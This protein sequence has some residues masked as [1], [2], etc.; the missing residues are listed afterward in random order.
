V[1]LTVEK[2]GLRAGTAR[3]RNL[4]GSIDG[5]WDG[6]RLALATDIGGAGGAAISVTADVPLAYNSS[7]GSISVPE[8]GALKVDGTWKAEIAPL[9]QAIGSDADFLAG[10]LNASLSVTG[11]VGDPEVSGQFMLRDGDFRNVDFGTALHDVTADVS[12]SPGHATIETVT[13]TDGKGGTFSASGTVDFPQDAP[14]AVNMKVAFDKLRAMARPDVTATVTGDLT[15]TLKDKKSL[16]KG[17]VTTNHIEARLI[18]STSA[19]VVPLEV[20]EIPAPLHTTQR[21]TAPEDSSPPMMLDVDVNI[22]QEFFIRGRGLDSE[23]KGGLKVTGPADA[24]M[25]IG[26][27]NVIRGNFT[28]SGKRFVLTQG[29]VRFNGNQPINPDVAIKAEYETS[30]ITAIVS[31]GGTPRD[32]EISFSSNPALPEDEVVS[33]VLFGK[34]VTNLSALEAVQLASAMRSLSSGGEGLVGSARSAV[35]LDVLSFGS[36]ENG[37]GTV[38]RGGKYITKN[39]YLEV[40]SGTEPGSEQVGVEVDVTK[41]LSIE[42]HI[43]DTTGEDIGVYWK[44]DY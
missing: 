20:T 3:I 19:N 29:N 10:A 1:A 28:F 30:D 6:Q 4:D 37:D 34:G 22:P 16:L 8:D 12:L 23:W 31:V 44:K 26:D 21:A 33:N 41:N 35:G 39:V 40:Q 11:T 24:F 5:N 9:W 36:A 38:I 15:Y 13:A 17:E 43:N 18:S 14:A 27:V 25:L 7:R 2:M 42:T 32:I